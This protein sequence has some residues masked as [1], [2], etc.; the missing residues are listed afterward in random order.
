MTGEPRQPSYVDLSDGREVR[1]GGEC[2]IC[3]ARYASRS[4]PIQGVSGAPFRDLRKSA[5][6]QF[7]AAWRD[8]QV[9]CYH[10]SRGA[11]PECWDAESRTCVEC[12]DARGL[13]RAAFA[14]PTRG[15]LV[16]GRLALRLRTARPS[17]KTK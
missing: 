4:A 2:G 3:G 1:F 11:C 8:L 15:P 17:F 12:A 16:D 13:T 6:S 14:P 9:S 7:D 10:C 5:L